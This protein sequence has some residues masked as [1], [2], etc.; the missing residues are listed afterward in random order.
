MRPVRTSAAVFCLAA[1]TLLLELVLSRI[2]AAVF[3]NNY[4]FLIVSIALFGYAM[5]GVYLALSPRLQ[6]TLAT[7]WLPWTAGFFVMGLFGLVFLLRHVPMNLMAL[8]RE[9]VQWIYLGLYFIGVTWPFFWIGMVMA[10]LFTR[11]TAEAN[12]LYFWDLLGASTGS[13]L[14]FLLIR[15]LDGVGTLFAS[16]ILVLIALGVLLPR[17]SWGM[18]LP[19][20]IVVLLVGWEGEASFPLRPMIHKRGYNPER[21]EYSEWGVLT[22][23]DVQMHTRTFKV[24]WIDM[25]SN[26]SFMRPRR[27]EPFDTRPTHLTQFVLPYYLKFDRSDKRVLIVGPAGGYEVAVALA[28]RSAE[29]IGVEMDPTIVRLVTGHYNTLL[30]GL[31]HDPRVQLINDEGRSYIR[32][33]RRR[34]D[35][36][37]QINNATPIAVMH[38]AVNLAESYLTTREAFTD[39]WDHLTDDGYLSIHRWGA[40]RLFVQ[41]YDLLKRKGVAH[42]FRH[43]AVIQ[44]PQNWMTQSFLLK[45]RPLT[46]AEIRDIIRYAR[47]R[48][49][50]VLYVPGPPPSPPNLFYRIARAA[51]P[52]EFVH[53]LY[54]RTGLD[55]RPV[56]D[57]RPFFN[58]FTTLHP[59]RS[60]RRDIDP[61]LTRKLIEISLPTR[62]TLWGLLAFGC[63][64]GG[65]FLLWPLFQFNRRGLR[66]SIGLGTIVYFAGLGFGFI[67]IEICLF[68][69]LVLFLGAPM[70][71]ITFVL[72][73]VLLQAGVGSFLAGRWRIA[74]EHAIRRI[75]PILALTIGAEILWLRY[76]LNLFLHW[77]FPGR[78]IVA[79]LSLLPMTLW[80]GMMFP[81]GLR[82]IRQY[83]VS[84][85]PWA[86]GINGYTTVLG[87]VT[88]VIL[89]MTR[90]FSFV[91]LSAIFWY[92]LS[93]SVVVLVER[94][95]RPRVRLR[96]E[97]GG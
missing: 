22:R 19:W 36:I 46:Q 85:V 41:G 44:E 65:V 29:V 33:E 24:I 63:L 30:N 93:G 9:P 5:A 3:L 69:Q 95:Y 86:W 12:R 52:L 34:Y 58:Q 42:P 90:G 6:S 26:Q 83:S 68:Q 92:L 51:D 28:Y 37:Q 84:L 16:G 18:L 77:N 21:V 71:S 7:R 54:R 23:I 8:H 91:F 45:K 57:D 2:F 32:R 76:G 39:Y 17:A 4:A 31:Y 11:W 25:G 87:S 1:A 82:W 20:L 78:L 88:A 53:R 48:A 75:A 97:A 15:P 61:G 60:T 73:T 47:L 96:K 50:K 81:L 66:G 49:G 62:Y 55:L 74:P 94:G 40:L 56:T 80:M 67:A 27:T 89:A 79:F 10:D 13:L 59:F 64:M 38:G 14:L 70:Y 43:M 35:I 72:V